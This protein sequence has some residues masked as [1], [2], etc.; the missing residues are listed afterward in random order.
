MPYKVDWDKIPESAKPQIH[1]VLDKYLNEMIDEIKVAIPQ[2]PQRMKIQLQEWLRSFE[3]TRDIRDIEVKTWSAGQKAL[4][5]GAACAVARAKNFPM[6]FFLCKLKEKSR[7]LLEQM[8]DVLT[9][10]KVNSL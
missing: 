6:R 1:R 3:Y 10:Y 5:I 9:P 7:K 8:E 4:L 2:A